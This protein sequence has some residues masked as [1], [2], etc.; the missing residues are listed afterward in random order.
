MRERRHGR[1]PPPPPSHG[2]S[3]SPRDTTSLLSQSPPRR[4]TPPGR[5]PGHQHTNLACRE[6]RC[7]SHFE[8]SLASSTTMCFQ[9]AT[10]DESPASPHSTKLATFQSFPSPYSISL[11]P[12]L[13]MARRSPTPAP[14]RPANLLLTAPPAKNRRLT[15]SSKTPP[16]P[17]EGQ[18]MAVR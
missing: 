4:D 13:R 16:H 8:L 12:T 9:L 15:A 3:L 5:A 10:T 17:L 7:A 14:L 1:A 11:A 18:R 2:S 6:H